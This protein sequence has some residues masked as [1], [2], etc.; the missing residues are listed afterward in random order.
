MNPFR[1]FPHPPKSL[2]PVKQVLL[3][4]PIHFVVFLKLT[5]ALLNMLDPVETSILNFRRQALLHSTTLYVSSKPSRR[6]Y[7]TDILFEIY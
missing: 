5:A 2:K 1:D 6:V 7:A 4:E 3:Q